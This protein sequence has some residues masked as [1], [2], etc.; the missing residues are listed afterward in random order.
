M[1]L[2]VCMVL[3]ILLPRMFPLLSASAIS[4]G[5][6]DSEPDFLG[7]ILPPVGLVGPDVAP[8]AA[9]VGAVVAPPAAVVGDGAVV[10]AADAALGSF[11]GDPRV[12]TRDQHEDEPSHRDRT[13]SFMPLI[14]E[15][16][17]RQPQ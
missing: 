6:S 16:E 8:P 9:V 3:E 13:Y 4:V 12:R 1:L 10:A 2:F 17:I 5:M 14:Y 15:T 7:C 11:W